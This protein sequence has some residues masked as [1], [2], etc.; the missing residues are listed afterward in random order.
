MARVNINA[1][2]STGTV[3]PVI[4]D[5]AGQLADLIKRAYFNKEQKE[6]F[7]N[8]F[9]EDSAAIIEHMK[10]LGM[11][12]L[13]INGVKCTLSERVT[14]S[15]NEEGLLE[16]CK[17]LNIPGLVRT[18]EVVD[19]DVLGDLTYNLKIDPADIEQF[20]TK[21]ISESIRLSGKLVE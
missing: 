8:L 13:K 11:K 21:S 15:C 10:P 4:T 5:S 16:Y 6:R 2:K 3:Q 1:A 18:V 9:K 17:S 7:T 19:L 12:D 14:R 20:Y